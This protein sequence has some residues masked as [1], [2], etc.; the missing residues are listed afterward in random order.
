MNNINNH[1]KH[2]F[3]YLTSSNKISLLN[4]LKIRNV[5]FDL[6]TKNNY[7]YKTRDKDINLSD[8]TIETNFNWHCEN[9]FNELVASALARK[10]KEILLP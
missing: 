1:Q 8:L 4:L 5:N 10:G 9:D 6:D 2:I 3:G 7:C